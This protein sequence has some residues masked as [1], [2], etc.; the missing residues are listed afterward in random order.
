[1]AEGAD[2]IT[3]GTPATPT[4]WNQRPSTA[5]I[6]NLPFY[7][8]VN[9]FADSYRMPQ[10]TM[11]Y[12]LSIMFAVSVGYFMYW[13]G[14]KNLLAAIIATAIGLAIGA[15]EGIVQM[16]IPLFFC[17]IGISMAWMAQRY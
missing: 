2:A 16:W 4:S 1:L 12:G 11:W 9:Y 6:T 15:V 5:K 7:D 3:L 14:N 17:I 8:L 13:R 10:A